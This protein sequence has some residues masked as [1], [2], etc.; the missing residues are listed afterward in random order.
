MKKIS[1]ALVIVMLCTGM[2]F[3]ATLP[4]DVG[5]STYEAAITALSEKGIIT[6]EPDGK[7][8]PESS[9]TR[10]Q[11][12]IMVVKAMNPADSDINGTPT[13]TV[14]SGFPDMAGYGWAEGYIAYAVKKGVVKGYPDGTF[15]A[16]NK[17]TLQEITAMTL[18][19][20]GHTDQSLLGTYPSNYMEKAAT[21]GLLD[22][23]VTIQV[24][25][26]HVSKGLTAQILYNGLAMIEKAN[27][28][29]PVT[30]DSGQIPGSI[31]GILGKIFA[32]GTFNAA[33]TE[34][35]GKA[36]AS[37]VKVYTYGKKVDYKSTMTLSGD[38]ADY[39]TD[40]V[41]KYKN[42]ATPLWYVMTGNKIT[43]M[44]L[45]MDVGF[46]GYAYG[47]INDTVTTLNTGG[48]RVLGIKTLVAEKPIQWLGTTSLDWAP[49]AQQYLTGIVFE[50][51]LRDG[52]VKSIEQAGLDARESFTE[53]TTGS[54][55]VY[56]FDDEVVRINSNAGMLFAVKENASV[57]VLSDDQEEYTGGSLS[58]IRE[59]KYIRAYDM[60][61]DDDSSADIVVISLK[62]MVVA[63]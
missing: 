51:V 10:A 45:P 47:V 24:V 35:D 43:A 12:C 32:S 44:I 46:S 34:F 30:D 42:V 26:Y 53:L 50:F 48:D 55:T 60:T 41:Y 13:Q 21:L 17:V 40:T 23:I 61:D 19:A 6:G 1:I 56:T 27:P 33:M 20:G 22:D 28:K 4:S 25:P 49:G 62:E 14:D 18:R 31:P 57:Y 38:V 39:R 15:K 2:T 5:G 63:D 7:F 11:A 29:T 37:D 58:D 54:N 52:Q 16:G 9:L 36:I 8:H 59:G 3:A